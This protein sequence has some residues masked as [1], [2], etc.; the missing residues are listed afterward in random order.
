MILV[1]VRARGYDQGEVSLIHTNPKGWGSL[2]LS[3]YELS[4]YK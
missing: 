4:M 3:I 2:S 1:H